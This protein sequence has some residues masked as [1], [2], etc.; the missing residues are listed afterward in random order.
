MKIKITKSLIWFLVYNLIILSIFALILNV[1][2]K[3][4]VVVKEIEPQTIQDVSSVYLDGI[5]A[6]V[7][8]SLLVYPDPTTSIVYPLDEL[9]QY[10]VKDANGHL[11]PKLITEALAQFHEM[12]YDPIINYVDNQTVPDGSVID[13]YLVLGNQYAAAEYL[14]QFD[15]D[16]L[17]LKP[18]FEG[19]IELNVSRYG[20]QS[21]E[22]VTRS[23]PQTTITNTK[24][25]SLSKDGLTYYA[26]L[27]MGKINPIVLS[28]ALTAFRSQGYEPLLNYEGG[29][30]SSNGYVVG[31]WVLLDG[32]QVS[33]DYIFAFNQNDIYIKPG[34]TG[35]IQLNINTLSNN[36]NT[37]TTSTSTQDPKQGLTYFTKRNNFC[38]EPVFWSDAQAAFRS[39]GYEPSLNFEGGSDQNNGYVM[40][41]NVV[42]NGQ[43][44]NG[45]YIYYFDGDDIYIKPGFEG[46]IQLN[47]NTLENIQQITSGNG[48]GNGFAPVV[49]TSGLTYFTERNNF[50][51]QPVFW[52]DAQTAFRSQGYEPELNFEGGSD[53]NNGYVMCL[54]VFEGEGETQLSGDAIFTFS[55]NS[56]YIK[57]GF[58]GRI[59]LNINTQDNI[60]QF[61]SGN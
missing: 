35:Q 32:K 45:D 12:G 36:S 34:F 6:F 17:Y 18:D 42:L 49:D 30:N 52:S 2:Q 9:I 23:T 57:P 53:Q 61:S 40:C 14:F 56:I 24:T 46:S 25:T 31:L 54:N 29:S 10:G 22:T 5:N 26:T 59:R 39:Q 11:S 19:T 58:G 20:Y 13:I 55:G 43:Q 38:F 28:D 60:A 3:P 27:N 7:D 21:S 15:E 37:T 33:G 8:P 50:C 47:I 44:V 51:F 4:E 16:V 48:G 41:L 1:Q